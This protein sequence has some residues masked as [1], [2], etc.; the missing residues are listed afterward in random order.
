[1]RKNIERENLN[2]IIICR[3]SD[4]APYKKLIPYLLA[5]T[6]FTGLIGTF[7]SM[8]RW[9]LLRIS[10]LFAGVFSFSGL[11]DGFRL[12]FNRLFE[13]SE[14]YQY[15]RY[16]MFHINSPES[17]WDGNI[18]IALVIIAAFFALLSMVLSFTS[19]KSPVIV[20][21]TIVSM[22]Q[23]YFGVFPSAVW[24]II[25]FAAFALMLVSRREVKVTAD[26]RTYATIVAFLILVAVIIRVINPGTS[27]RFSELSESIRDHFDTRVSQISG[28]LLNTPDRSG[29]GLVT[30]PESRALNIVDVRDD[31]LNEMPHDDYYVEYDERI[32][33]A[34]IGAAG[35]VPSL[36]PILLGVIALAVIVAVIRLLP[37]LRKVAVRQK[38]FALDD[39]PVAIN[40]MFIYMLEWLAV[41]GLKRKNI[42]FSAYAP[43]LSALVSQQYAKEYE[44]I[45][46]LWCEAVY[47]N[48]TIGEPERQRMRQFLDKTKSI[49]WK[50]S[51]VLTRIQIKIDYF[52]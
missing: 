42:V 14:Q 15:Y 19:R 38:N 13:V 2:G 27:L 4:I 50:N 20:L 25:L 49:V 41:Y 37:P 48:H 46:A 47:S 3:A 9:D 51:G 44:S 17:L 10:H 34:E 5:L 36:L 40:N 22:A 26:F 45:A 39:C 1:M 18:A 23:V 21:F 35:P 52:L 31:S 33:G 11:A 28:T 24:N 43:Q 32:W 8:L 16:V 30:E 29:R 6:L 12:V 7:M